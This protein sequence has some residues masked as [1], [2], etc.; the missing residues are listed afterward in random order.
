ML[1]LATAACA[2][3]TPLPRGGRPGGRPGAAPPDAGDAEYFRINPLMVP[4]AG[5]EPARV[6][7]SFNEP[8]DGG[9]LH[10]ASDLVAPRGTPVVAA[11]SGTILRLSQNTRGGN[12]IYMSDDDGRFVYYYAHLDRYSDR[13]ATGA[14]V[15][16]GTVIGYVGSSGNAPVPHLHF[17][18]MRR[19]PARSDYWNGAPVDVRPYFSVVGRRQDSRAR[20]DSQDSQGSRD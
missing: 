2:H 1:V 12:T 5:V 3:I 10:R 9:R 11:A 13:A 15:W 16:Q 8:R 20:Q 6:P 4:V 19:D 18:A 7:D 17:Q 14:H